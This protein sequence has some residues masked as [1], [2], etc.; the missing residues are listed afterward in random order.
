MRR[1]HKPH[2]N[3]IFSAAAVA[4]LALLSASCSSSGDMFGSGSGG[5][6]AS[7]QSFSDRFSRMLSGGGSSANA[8]AT[9]ASASP[10]E[11]ETPSYCPVVDVRQGAATLSVVSSAPKNTAETATMAL[12]YQGT[13]GETARECLIT[14]GNLTMKVGV[15][16]RLI[17]GPEG[18]AGEVEVP[19]R[20]ALIQEGPEPKT[21]WTKLYRFPIVVGEGQSSVPFTHVQEDI[22]VPRPRPSDLE[23]YVVYIGFDTLSMKPPAAKKPAPKKR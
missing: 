16:G 4:G 20:Y 10:T 13:I 2:S 23:N 3:L 21:L 8:S 22:A 7:Q 17:L 9:T 15:Q 19:L 14:N 6:S 12:R 5:Q 18:N 11:S 1:V